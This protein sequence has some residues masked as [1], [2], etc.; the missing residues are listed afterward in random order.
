MNTVGGV[1]DDTIVGTEELAIAESSLSAETISGG[2]SEI[3]THEDE[4]MV[5]CGLPT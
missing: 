5:G 2:Y 3:S 1:N 4:T